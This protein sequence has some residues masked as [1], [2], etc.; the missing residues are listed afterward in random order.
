MAQGNR[1]QAQTDDQILETL[2]KACEKCGCYEECDE[3]CML[4]IAN[5]YV[6]CTKKCS[7]EEVKKCEDY[8]VTHDILTS[9]TDEEEPDYYDD[10]DDL[11]NYDYEE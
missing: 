11:E 6:V 10:Y 3:D 5:P 8:Y 9:S 2:R 1:A 7:E 4:G